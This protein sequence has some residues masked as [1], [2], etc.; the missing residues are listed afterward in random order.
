MKKIK[1]MAVDDSSLFRSLVEKA[2]ANTPEVEVVC[3]AANGKIALDQLRHHDVDLIILDLEMPEMDG[4][5]TI[6]EIN[7]RGL[8]QKIILFSATTTVGAEKTLLALKLGAHD[9]VPKPI[10]DGS[11]QTPADKI[12][13]SLLSKIISLCTPFDQSLAQAIINKDERPFFNWNAFEP[14]V[15]VI[16]SSTGGPNAL[17]EVLKK[18][19]APIHIP[20]LITQHMPA[21]F[22]T[23]LAERLGELSCKKCLEGID[24]EVIKP[25]QIYL[26]PGNYHMSLTGNKNSPTIKLDQ[27]P[28]RNYVRPCADFLFE[29]ATQIYGNKVLGIVLT[30]MGKDGLDGVRAIKS[31]QGAVIIQNQ[32]SSVVFGMPGAVYEHNLYDFMGNLDDIAMKIQSLTVAKRTSYAS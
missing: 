24:G 14:E 32:E 8:T 27:G 10:A 18:L 3:T 7:A 23:T 5:E 15:I 26:A 16:A 20:I 31:K 25:N 9:F 12:R 28:Q 30:G 29:S 1:L 22:T 6:K 4:I 21:V 11:K 2:F 17:S 13:E 19:K